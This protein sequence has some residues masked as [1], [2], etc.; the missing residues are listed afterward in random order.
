[1]F[2]ILPTYGFKLIDPKTFDSNKYSSNSSKGCVLE[3]DL[4]YPKELWELH[5]DNPLTP[6]KIEINKK[7]LSS[8]QLKI[9]DFYNI[10]IGNLKNWCLNFLIKKSMCFST[11]TC[12]F[13]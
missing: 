13:T 5:N 8:N 9:A 6:D 3:V 10:P 1:M 12:K 2:K 7:M 11:I 4:E